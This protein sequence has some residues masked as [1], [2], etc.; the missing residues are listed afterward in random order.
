M[1]ELPIN[2]LVIVAIAVIILLSIVAL[3]FVG[4]SPFG[5]FISLASLKNQGCSNYSFNYQCGARGATTSDIKFQTNSYKVNN[6][7]ELCQNYFNAS[8]ESECRASCGCGATISTGGG[9]GSCT[10]GATSCGSCISGNPPKF[11]N[12]ASTIVDNCNQCPSCPAGQSCQADGSCSSGGACSWQQSH[13]G[14]DPIC[15]CNGGT[16]PN[17]LCCSD[18]GKPN[19]E[20]VCGLP[21]CTGTCSGGYLPGDRTCNPVVYC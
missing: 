17:C 16:D 21:G 6:L 1:P 8:T 7:F 18:S 15:L 2:I 3:Y 11:C 5:G 19:Y 12:S 10:C 20:Y 9:P 4:W 13:C 14:D